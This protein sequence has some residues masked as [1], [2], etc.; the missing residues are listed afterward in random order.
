MVSGETLDWKRNK[1]IR[2]WESR[3]KKT[4]HDSNPQFLSFLI[5]FLVCKSVAGFVLWLLFLTMKSR[6][7]RTYQRLQT[8]SS[9]TFPILIFDWIGGGRNLFPIRKKTRKRVNISQATSKFPILNFSVFWDWVYVAWLFDVDCFVFSKKLTSAYHPIGWF[10]SL[11]HF[12]FL[13]KEIKRET[14]YGK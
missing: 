5:S 12:F 4:R 11:F 3:R 14:A 6:T 13:C 8:I 7:A 1:K 2:N 9:S 10:F